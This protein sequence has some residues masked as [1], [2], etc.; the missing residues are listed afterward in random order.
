LLTARVA[1]DILQKENPS[2]LAKAE[3]LLDKFSDYSTQ[4]HEDKYKFVE[5]VT[6]PDDI[7]RIG[8]GWQSAWHFDDQPIMGDNSDG[9][10]PKY[11]DKNISTAMPAIYK[12]LTGGDV[13]GSAPIDTIKKHTKS[14]D[15]AKSVAL[16]LIIH[17]M[18]DIHQPLH[19]SD[20]YTSGHPDGD[21]GGNDFPLKYH[22]TANELHAVW[23]TV[24][25]QYHTSIKRPF[26]ASTFADQEKLATELRDAF[27]FTR[28]QVNTIDFANF[29]DESF[30]IAQHV[31]DNIHEGKTEVLPQS[32]LD[33]Y[34]AIAKRRASLAGHRLAY[35]IEQIFSNQGP[36]DFTL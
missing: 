14:E 18:G 9:I 33:K 24:V 8:G 25:Y 10:S 30:T 31:Y 12:Y 5:C 28:N 7:K 13:T 32:Y 22:Y 35:L 34:Q 4:K 15:E 17:Y 6:W 23:D 2:A 21:K 16:R 27:T 1:Y 36:I 11:D 3:A 26:T 19:C 29:R 20:R